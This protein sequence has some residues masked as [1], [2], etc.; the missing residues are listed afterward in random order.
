MIPT[1]KATLNRLLKATNLKYTIKMFS[2]YNTEP[3]QALLPE[4]TS[5]KDFH[6]LYE[7]F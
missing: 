1:I 6:Q 4:L 7:I 2:T 3:I 5:I